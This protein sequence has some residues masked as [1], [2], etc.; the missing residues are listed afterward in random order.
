MAG[1]LKCDDNFNDSRH[2]GHARTSYGTVCRIVVD[3]IRTR[4]SLLRAVVG[5]SERALRCGRGDRQPSENTL[6]S[7]HMVPLGCGVSLF[8]LLRIPPLMKHGAMRGHEQDL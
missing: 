2:H 4:R 6:G 7:D 8:Q 5:I 1:A 3:V